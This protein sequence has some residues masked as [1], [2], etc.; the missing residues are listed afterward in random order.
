MKSVIRTL[1]AG[2]L[3]AAV[4][5][6]TAAAS[7]QAVLEELRAANREP[8]GIPVQGLVLDLGQGELRLDDGMLYVLSGQHQVQGLQKV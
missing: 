7:P 6:L 2:G 5:S 3:V 8:G 4:A 1:V